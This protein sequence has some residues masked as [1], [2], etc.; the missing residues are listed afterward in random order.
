MVTGRMGHDHRDWLLSLLIDRHGE[1]DH[2]AHPAMTAGLIRQVL[3]AINL[4]TL[5]QGN[6]YPAHHSGSS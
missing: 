5:D 6:K 1:I 2:A 4:K 3:A